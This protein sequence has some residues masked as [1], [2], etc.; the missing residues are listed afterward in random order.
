[1]IT[2]YGKPTCVYC[3]KAKK[4]AAQYN[5]KFEYIDIDEPGNM[6]IF[7]QKLPDATSVPQIFWNVKYIGGYNEF[8]SEIQDTVGGYGEGKL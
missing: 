5:F 1:M 3:I 7:K 6:E 4:L 2:I 8:A